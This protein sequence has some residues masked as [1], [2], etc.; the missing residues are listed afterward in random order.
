MNNEFNEKKLN[1]TSFFNKM[2][3]DS[4]KRNNNNNISQDELDNEQK[5][6]SRLILIF[7]LQQ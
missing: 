3:S 7:E 2:E 1:S 6:T 4:Y 5:V